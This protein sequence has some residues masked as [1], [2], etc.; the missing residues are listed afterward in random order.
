M[1]QPQPLTAQHQV[2]SDPRLVAHYRTG[3]E[4]VL[5]TSETMRALRVLRAKRRWT[6]CLRSAS[7]DP[8]VVPA[9]FLRR[10]PPLGSRRR[11]PRDA[12]AATRTRAR[13][14]EASSRVV[15]AREVK[16]SALGALPPLFCRRARRGG[17]VRPTQRE[18]RNWMLKLGR[19]PRSRFKSQISTADRTHARTGAGTH[20]RDTRTSQINLDLGST[21]PPQGK[22][23]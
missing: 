10:C 22:K 14:Q 1:A 19:I 7:C 2:R 15:K 4:M 23:K 16:G 20:T 6:H 12:H 21:K 8:R 3:R 9:R 18:S 11:W 17:A 5:E 13:G